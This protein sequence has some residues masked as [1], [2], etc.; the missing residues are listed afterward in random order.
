MYAAGVS[1]GLWKSTTS[2]GSWTQIM[3]SGDEETE[4]IP[5]LAIASMCQAANGDIYFGT[6]E[7]HYKGTG[8]GSRGIE[9]AGIWKSTDGENF[10]RL[11]STWSDSDSKNTF[12]YV[13]KLA[14]DPTDAN[15]LFAATIRGVRLTENGGQTWVNPVT[16]PSGAPILFSAG[17]VKISSD[18]SIVIASLNG[19]AYLSNQEEQAGHSQEFQ[20][21][22]I[23]RLVMQDALN[24]LSHQAILIT[25]TAKHQ[26]Q[27][28]HS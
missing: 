4:D 19:Q 22:V 23:T 24:L 6:G 25:F 21:P 10:V 18:G 8:T 27:M 16:Q 1:G 13:N 3:Y 14:A 7:G 26:N 9:G 12:N 5:N 17:D 20:E 11:S 2:G 28:V 15:R